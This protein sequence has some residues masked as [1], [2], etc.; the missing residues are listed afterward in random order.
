MQATNQRAW[1][2]RLALML[3]LGVA[4]AAACV[5]MFLW[6]KAPAASGQEE[7]SPTEPS[8]VARC[9]FSHRA[10]VDPIVDFGGKAHHMHDFFANT[11]TNA[12]S[13]LESLRAGGTTCTDHPEDTAAYWIPKVSWTDSRGTTTK[14]TASQTRFYYRLGAKSPNVDVQPHPAGLKIVTLQGKN[15]EWRCFN[16][17]WS[18]TPPTQC[19][20]GKLVVR[21]KFPDCLAKDSNGPLLDSADHRS[22]M[23]DAVQPASGG[24]ATCPSTHPIPVPRLQTNVEF[25]IPTTRGK[26][27]LSSGAYS[28]MHAD[29][30]NA[31]Q[32]G[33]LEDLVARCIN[34]GPF[35]ATNSKPA[36]CL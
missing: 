33:V 32:E 30:F 29:F 25:P 19:S 2:A 28:T 8:F 9:E 36:D 18:T 17:T 7:T 24:K 3:I 22:H 27:K 20:N 16:G 5:A 31:W 35:T 1:Q 14:L 15:V 10:L 13:T 26:P 23:V 4:A 21:V 6:W 34:A 12:K 11:T